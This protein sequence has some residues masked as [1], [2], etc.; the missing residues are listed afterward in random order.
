MRLLFFLFISIFPFL[1][2][3]PV[4]DAVVV[5]EDISGKTEIAAQT[6]GEKGKA[7]F[8]FLDEGSYRLIV[9]FPQQKG[10]W[11]RE[12]PKYST[13]TKAT[14]DKKKRCYYYQGK[15]GYFV[16]K[17]K[18]ARKIDHETFHPVFKELRGSLDRYIVIAEF[19][20]IKDGAQFYLQVKK[21]TAA[22]FKK[23]TDKIPSDI[24][25]IS[26]RGEK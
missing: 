22:Q 24:S 1:F 15:E 20:T 23:A 25:L 7:A 18:R 5:L 14:F 6:V 26:I 9:R 17:F 19:L 16:V 4:K 13:L 8:L 11:T 12:K 21:L 3:K 10:K 2:G